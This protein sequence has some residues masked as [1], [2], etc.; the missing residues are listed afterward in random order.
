MEF[1]V[2]LHYCKKKNLVLLHF[3]YIFEEILENEGS[4]II[5]FLTILL[6]KN[7]EVTFSIIPIALHFTCVSLKQVTNVLICESK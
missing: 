7:K 4:L 3:D 2:F 1:F 6:V 5:L